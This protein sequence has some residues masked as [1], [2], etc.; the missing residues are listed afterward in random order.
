MADD[1]RTAPYTVTAETMSTETAQDFY[2]LLRRFECEQR[3][4]PRVGRALRLAQEVVR[5]G[6]EASLGF[7]AGP[8]ASVVRPAADAAWRIQV[9][10]FGMLGPNGPLPLNWTEYVR[11]RWKHHADATF[12]R[13]LDV[14]HH[15]ML[16]LFYRAWADAQPAVQHDRLSEDRFATYVASLAGF[17]SPSLRDRDALPDT[18]KLFYAGRFACQARHP[19]GLLAIIG[20][21]FDVPASIEEFMGEWVAIAD[22]HRWRLGD[23]APLGDTFGLGQLGCGTHLGDRVWLRQSRFRIVLGPLTRAQFER[24]APGGV[25]VAALI[26]LVRTYVGDELGWDLLLKLRQDAVPTFALGVAVLG[27]ATWLQTSTAAVSDDLLYQPCA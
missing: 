8:I 13:F 1:G 16:S 10:C 25:D 4:V 11:Q 27:K 15:R 12:A 22:R 21:Q 3:Q 19:E 9:H 6:Q 7:A 26:A 2:Q 5:L 14:F 20:G 23:S 24:L 18:V 17:G